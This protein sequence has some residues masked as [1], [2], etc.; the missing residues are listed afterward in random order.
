MQLCRTEPELAGMF[1]QIRHQLT[2]KGR[3][4][5]GAAVTAGLKA[6]TAVVTASAAESGPVVADVR[7]LPAARAAQ[8]AKHAH[9]PGR[10]C[11][12]VVPDGTLWL[13]AT[14]LKHMCACIP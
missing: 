8:A 4:Y 6:V 10:C 7:S 13:R 9:L 2:E 5:K 11:R 3:E 12:P 14:S 1:K